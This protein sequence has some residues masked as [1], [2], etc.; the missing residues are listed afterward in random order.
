MFWSTVGRMII[1]P[2]AFLIAAVAALFVLFSL[3]LENLTQAVYAR[4]SDRDPEVLFFDILGLWG[5]GIILLSA[6]TLLPA[7]FVIVLGEVV[8]IRS[9]LYY[10]LGGGLALVAIPLLASYSHSPDFVLPASTVWQSF[11]TAGFAG[12][13]IYWLIAGRRA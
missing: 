2:I 13:F 7:L 11:A 12:G 10:V 3:G 5:Q 6:L 8:R 1:V 4:G 9:W